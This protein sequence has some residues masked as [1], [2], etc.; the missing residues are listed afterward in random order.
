MKLLLQRFKIQDIE[1]GGPRTFII[2]EAGVNHNGDIDLAKELIDEAVKTEVDAIKFQ[3]FVTEELV[4][5][6]APKAD[7]QQE[8]TTNDESQYE[9]IKKLELSFEAFKELKI[10]AENQ[11]LLFISTPFDVQSVEYLIK[12]KVPAFKVGSGDM[13]NII[14]LERI[15]KE[16]KPILLSTGM[17]TLDE[18]SEIFHFL[19]QQGVR[20]L[21]L[22]HCVTNY[23]APYSSLN[24]RVISTL[25]RLFDVPIGFS[26]HSLGIRIP[27]LA[28]ASG[29]CAIEKHFTLDKTLPGPD[30]K[31]SLEP[32]EL[33]EMVKRIRFTDE[34]L[35]SSEKIIN[36]Q[37]RQIRIAA[38]KSIVAIKDIPEGAILTQD[39][40]GVKRPG[41]GISPL[42][43]NKIIGKKTKQIIQKDRQFSWE[44]LDG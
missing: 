7:Y 16:K 6:Y 11:N 4:T 3:T 27:E 40:L 44:M 35:G 13:N 17:A 29:A 14:L 2:A 15:T 18:I 28:V 20:E 31:A 12:L 21:L 10:H 23:P 38:R 19:E 43:L 24:L 36:A 41:N 30:H 1:V 8:T 37:E 5:D 39:D 42:F 25:K 26:D 22:F 9:M 32:E 33:K 34:V